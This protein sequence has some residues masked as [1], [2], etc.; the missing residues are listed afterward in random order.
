MTKQISVPRGTADILPSDIPLWQEVET[1]ARKILKV[2]GFSEIRTPIYEDIGLF[3]RSLGQTSDVVNKQLLEIAAAGDEKKENEYALRPEGTAAVVRS[4]IENRLDAKESLSKLFYIGPM[5]RGERPQKGRLRQFHQIGLESIGPNTTS[6]FLDAEMIGTSV[7]LLHEFGISQFTL[8]INSLGTQEDK[9]NF[10]RLLREKL[11]SK[12]RELCEDCQSRF[13]RNVFRVLDCKNPGCRQVVDSFQF[14]DEHLSQPSRE[15]FKQV[16]DAVSSL[17]LS[18][19]FDPK[20]VRGLDYYTHTVFEFVGT[21]LGSQDA[22][23][24]GGRYNN[25]V[26]DLGG[27]QPADAVGVALGIERILLAMP[28][29][30]KASASGLDV[31]MV[32]L[33]ETA[34]KRAFVIADF[35]RKG[36]IGTDMI[37]KPGA[38]MKSQMRLADKHQA[39]YVVILGEEEEKAHSVIVKDMSTGDQEMV[40]WDEAV[41]YLKK[42]ITKGST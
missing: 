36:N 41:E 38:S 4:Y 31:F 18:Y 21:S 15:Y 22:L 7:R 17:S 24:A 29:D 33:G 40:G 26:T 3:K 19:E 42:K 1:K 23:G 39:K 25:L 37:S 8:K 16:R 13:E 20:L 28:K 34:F 11:K 30:A 12:L 2:Y 35:M 5:F 32:A 10:S 6:P 9:E 14:S 27:P